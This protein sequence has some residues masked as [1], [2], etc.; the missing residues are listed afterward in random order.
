M[1]WIGVLLAVSLLWISAVVA[2][3]ET[4]F[5]EAV[6]TDMAPDDGPALAVAMLTPDGLWTA[7]TGL[8]DGQRPAMTEDRFR[9]GSMSKTYVAV[10]VLQLVEAEQL[11]LDDTAADWLD[12]AVLA[13]LA[14]ADQATVRQLLA[15]RSGIDDYLVQDDFWF[16]VED[17]PNYTWTAANA[18]AY[19]DGL[20]ALFA[21]DE[22]FNYSNSNYLLVE[23]I[24]EE[25][26]GMP[27]H[28][29]MRQNI[30]EPLGLENTYT[31]VSESLPGGFVSGYEDFDG[32]GVAEDLSGVNDGAG[33]ADGGLVS[34]VADVAR[35]Y[36]ALFVERSL[37]GEAMMTELLN[38]QDV[39]D[40]D[41]YG[42]GLNEA[43][44]DF[45]PQWGHSGGVLGFL[46]VG[47]YLPD[48]DLTVIVLS[49][50]ADL[51]PAEVMDEVLYGWLEW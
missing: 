24:F 32:D 49:A 30:F 17:D 43:D 10:A 46:S 5:L 4:D 36:E 22:A 3:E 21:P 19:A 31:Q 34:T 27:L 2:Q 39:G 35:F 13:N 29:W 45:G 41:G 8:A 23:L 42:L 20:P 38:F 15:M 1:R 37:L 25:A 16:A 48:E 9:I 12:A 18:L 28:Q 44:S 7:A 33:L 11:S 51:D 26:A 14:N 40:G 50:S 47:T 6:V